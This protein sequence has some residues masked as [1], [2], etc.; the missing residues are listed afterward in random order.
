MPIKVTCPK[1]Q[2][3]L[4]APDDAGGKRG[5]CPTCGT[6]L[7]IPVSGGTV[8]G[9][10]LPPPAVST[11]STVPAGGGK[12]LGDAQ[13]Y[14]LLPPSGEA[15]RQSSVPMLPRPGEAARPAPGFG[16]PPPVK[17]PA[18]AFDRP[19]AD[20][21]ATEVK[22][23]RRARRGL[24]LV[25]AGQFFLLLAG[26]AGPGLAIGRLYGLTLPEKDGGFLGKGLS[27]TT[28]IQYGAVLVPMAL[29]LLL[30]VIGRVGFGNLPRSS[31]ARGPAKWGGLFAL[32][33]VMGLVTAAAVSGSSFLTGYRPVEWKADGYPKLQFLPTDELT[34]RLQVGGLLAFGLFAFLA[35]ACF[36][37]AVGRLAANLRHDRAAARHTRFLLLAHLGA[38]LLGAWFA[39]RGLDPA[40]YAP[41]WDWVA[42]TWDDTL[43]K[44]GQAR[45]AVVFGLMAVPPLAVWFLY[46]RLTGGARRAVGDWLA[47]HDG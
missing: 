20:A 21:A 27:T 2:G 7:A 41:V 45:P 32:L 33:A 12:P 34:G 39:F 17:K 47:A 31:F 23:Y 9:P 10:A 44:V 1:C 29:G 38:G 11:P 40:S 22:G 42:A 13:G 25:Q 43:G 36:V 6:V 5:K 8:P 18:R 16:A 28:E 37:S 46:A 30:L 15:A 4:H 19:P 3:V 35:E 26:L 14:G 24:G